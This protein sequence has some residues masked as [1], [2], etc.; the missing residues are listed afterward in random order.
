MI[1]VKT[2]SAGEL[3]GYA[4][5][6]DALLIDLRGRGEYGKSHVRG[7]VNIPY[8]ELEENPEIRFPYGKTLVLYCDRGGASMKAAR[9]LASVGY[10]TCSVIGGYEAYLAQKKLSK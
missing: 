1:P 2:V 7:A 4:A 8:E 5:R 3:D 10:E 9:L 6:D